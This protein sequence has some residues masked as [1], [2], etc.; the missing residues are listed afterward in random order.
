V[1]I[2]FLNELDFINYKKPSMFIGFPKC[3]F[4]CGRDIC[5]NAALIKEPNIEI[6]ID[7]LITKYLNNPLSQ[8]VVIG[9]L[10]PFDSWEDLQNFI[11]AFRYWSGDE[12]VIYSGYTEEE[13]GK[14]KLDWLELYEPIIVKFGRYVP[15][16]K[17]HY[18]KVLGVELAS[19]NQYAKKFIIGDDYSMIKINPDEELVA[20]IRQAL[21]DNEGFCPCRPEKTADTKCI[22]K[23]FREQESGMC[24]CGLYIKE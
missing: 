3:S 14:E 1:K 16:Q 23:E 19:D 22:C 6:R 2:K 5:Q 12:V 21:R 17:P 20:E 13:L 15:S 8:A 7:D 9:G 11:R 18:D 10:E 24:H 4:K